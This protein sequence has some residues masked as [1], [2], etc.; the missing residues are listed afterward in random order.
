MLSLKISV[1]QGDI[2]SIEKSQGLSLAVDTSGRSGS[3]AIGMGGVLLGERVFSGMIRH[4]AE[5]FSS[6]DSLLKSIDKSAGEVE[7]IFVISGPGSFT[8]LRIAITFAKMYA[9]AGGARIVPVS[10]MDVLVANADEAD[11]GDGGEI[12]R[13][14]TI[15][16]AK[17]GR[18]FVAV[19]E[20]RDGEWVKSLDDCIMTAE[21]FVDSVCGDP[22]EIFLLG[23]GLMYYSKAFSGDSIHVL[24]AKYW[25]PSAGKLFS[26][27][28]QRADLGLFADPVE[29]LPAYLAGAGALEKWQR[30][31]RNA[32]DNVS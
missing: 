24:D 3:V 23:E 25:S 14:G 19:F 16:D 32:E 9:L 31:K 22:G 1:M 12:R 5:L 27:A 30:K 13:V 21:Q 20:K 17:R 28:S 26:I 2:V 4:S 11:I 7:N 10:T 29:V 8:G 18:F 6:S 15:L